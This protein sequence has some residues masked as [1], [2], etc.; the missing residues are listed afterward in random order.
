VKFAVEAFATAAFKSSRLHGDAVSEGDD[1]AK[2]MSRDLDTYRKHYQWVPDVCLEFYQL[3]A[4]V[5]MEHG[6]LR[7][8]ILTEYANTKELQEACINAQLMKNNMRRAM[9]DCIYMEYVVRG[10]KLTK[11]AAAA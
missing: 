6:I 8:E 1:K 7:K 10:T 9:A 3:H 5:D 4:D 2:S 11:S